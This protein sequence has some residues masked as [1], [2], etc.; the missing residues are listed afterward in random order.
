MINTLAATV[1]LTCIAAEA[2][3]I[4]WVID[5]YKRRR[6]ERRETQKAKWAAKYRKEINDRRTVRENR[7]KLWEMIK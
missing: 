4:Q 5:R 6:E 1:V 2:Y 7:N 3:C